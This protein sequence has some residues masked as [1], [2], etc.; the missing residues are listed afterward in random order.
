MRGDYSTFHFDVP[1]VHSAE[2]T[3]G[4]GDN[5][6]TISSVLQYIVWQRSQVISNT[7]NQQ[8]ICLSAKRAEAFC[9]KRREQALAC[10]LLLAWRAGS[11][12]FMLGE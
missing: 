3:E 7:F 9:Y 4:G 11:F 6:E 2:H 5:K 1:V 8:V 12:Y 10:N